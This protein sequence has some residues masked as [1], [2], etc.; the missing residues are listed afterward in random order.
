MCV[1]VCV[2]VC[3]QLLVQIINN[4]QISCY[5]KVNITMW[6]FL[7]CWS[8]HCSCYVVMWCDA[9]L[10]GDTAALLWRT[11]RGSRFT[12]T[13]WSSRTSKQY[14]LQWFLLY[15]NLAD[16]FLWLAI[17][18]HCNTLQMNTLWSR[19]L[20][21]K[22]NGSQPVKK[23]P[24]FYGTQRFITTFTCPRHLFLSWASLIQSMSPHPTSWRSI[25]IL[26][27]HLHLGLHMNMKCK[28]QLLSHF[29]MTVYHTYVSL[30]CVGIFRCSG[31]I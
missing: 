28:I 15:W 6:N 30:M 1:C 11:I 14:C 5:L 19:V 16:L 10:I 31:K 17:I 29:Y 7:Y 2:C 21:E 23:F 26:S 3:V 18:N 20:L 22:L 12:Q 24:A 13:F 8:D 25:L 9:G 4:M 27:S